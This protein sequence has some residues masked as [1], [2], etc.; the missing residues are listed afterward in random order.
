M[1]GRVA[2]SPYHVMDV[3]R[4]VRSVLVCLLR[5][6]TSEANDN[7]RLQTGVIVLNDARNVLLMFTQI[8]LWCAY[9][10]WRS[11]PI[12][13]LLAL[14]GLFIVYGTMLPFQFS[15][16]IAHAEV[17]L[18]RIWEQRWPTASRADLV[19]NVLLFMPWGF[20]LATWRLERGM[21]FIGTTVLALLSG[22]LLS[23]SVECAQLFT[24]SRTTS[25]LDLATNTA[26]STL[27]ALI[28]WPFARRVWPRI[29]GRGRQ[30]AI[31]RP[32]TACALAAAAGMMITALSPFDINV[33]MA[34][35]KTAIKNARL[36]PFGPTLEGEG[37]APPKPWSW[38]SDL[39]NW[40]LAGGLFAL[41]AQEQGRRGG[42]A[43]LCPVI[44]A[45]GLCLATEF[46]QIA[47]PS[48][49]IDMTT[50]L[51]AVLGSTIGAVSVVRSGARH[52]HFWIV[53]GLSIWG[54]L[55]VLSHWTPPD[56]A[57]PL[58]PFFRPEWLV[59]F[60]SYYVRTSPA[61][62]ADLIDELLIFVPLGV[63]LAAGS[64]RRSILQAV[65]IGFAVVLVLEAGQLFLPERTAELTDALSAAVGAGLGLALWRCGESVR[66]PTNSLGHA[67]YRVGP[68]DE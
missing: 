50:V 56:I 4:S 47:I 28:G 39:L 42:H 52:A 6:L 55:A 3:I 2:P 63:L 43:I 36:V 60:W 59:P 64:K 61:A 30:L 67:R 62:L 17:G 31:Q 35:L 19:S 16:N 49:Q 29:V 8:R 24:P 14:W 12:V 38:A 34:E 32:L 15:A 11:N 27:G 13:V 68:T 44:A 45:G 65:L 18:R 25:L 41:A 23:G 26:G 40:T 53:P 20:L 57:W 66:D 7:P 33:Q 1:L 5:M 22:A 10:R 9:V 21:S 46:I 51:M 48:R 58:R 37:A 54:A